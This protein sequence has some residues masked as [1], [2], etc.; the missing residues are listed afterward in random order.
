MKTHPEGHPAPDVVPGDQKVCTCRPATD[1]ADP[2]REGRP[3]HE[4]IYRGED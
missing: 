1:A 4:N 3:P 2:A